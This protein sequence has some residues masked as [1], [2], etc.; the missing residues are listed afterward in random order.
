MRFLSSTCYRPRPAYWAFGGC[1]VSSAR[2]L[3]VSPMGYLTTISATR[4]KRQTWSD[5]MNS[6]YFRLLLILVLCLGTTALFA[7]DQAA[8]DAAKDTAKVSR[9]E[10]KRAKKES[11]DAAQNTGDA[12]A[13]AGQNTGKK[14]KK[15]SKDAAKAAEKGAQKAEEPPK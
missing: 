5:A 6:K 11:T 1:P 9:K 3:A 2:C 13:D 4:P 10:A 14:V 8:R 12:T 15:G 7:Q